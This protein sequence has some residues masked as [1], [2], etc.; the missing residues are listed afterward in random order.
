MNGTPEEGVAHALKVF[1]RRR[2]LPRARVDSEEVAVGCRRAWRELHMPIT[3]RVD[4]D[5]AGF[6]NLEFYV[7][8]SMGDD[9]H[10]RIWA[11]GHVDELDAMHLWFRFDPTVPESKEIA[12]G[13]LRRHNLAVAQRLRARDLLP[14]A[15][16]G[17]YPKIL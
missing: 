5:D 14:E 1:L 11:E 12:Q 3:Y 9:Y 16:S 7:S 10:G 13:E 6:P 2:G 15:D 8:D 17:P 4:P